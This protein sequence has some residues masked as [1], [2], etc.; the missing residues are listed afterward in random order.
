MEKRDKQGDDKMTLK[1]KQ[2]LLTIIGAA[3]FGLIS[4]AWLN[5][6]INDW[7]ASVILPII[8][9]CTIINLVKSLD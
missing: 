3:F 9:I 4:C 6:Y 1:A 8:A 2:F 5:S 7:L